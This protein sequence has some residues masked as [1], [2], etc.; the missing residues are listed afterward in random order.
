MP[1]GVSQPFFFGVVYDDTLLLRDIPETPERSLI[2]PVIQCGPE[3]IKLLKPVDIVLPHCLYMDEVKKSS[4][5]VHRCE[6]YCEEGVLIF[7]PD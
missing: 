5:S 1:D 4:I 3:D 2:C 7:F 6:K